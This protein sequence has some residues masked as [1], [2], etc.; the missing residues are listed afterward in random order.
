VTDKADNPPF[1]SL[2]RLPTCGYQ[3][4]WDGWGPGDNLG[5]LNRLTGP[6]VAA[7][8]GSVRTGMRIGLTLPMELPD[9]GFFGRKP[10]R[11][12]YVPM[13][14]TAWDDYVDGL[15]LQISSQ[16]D[17]LRHVGSA[18]GWYGGWRGDPAADPEPLGIHH[19]AERGIIGRGVLVDLAGWATSA[20][21]AGPD[22]YDPFAH[23]AFQPDDVRAALAAQG[24]AL[25]PG[26]ILC[27]RTGWAEKYLTLDAAQRGELA[28][29]MQGIGGFNSA[30]L[31][32]SEDMARFLW[33]SG[34]AAVAAD[35]PSV[36][37][38][39]VDPAVGALHGRLIGPLGMA[40]GELF[41]FAALA[42]ACA[43]EKRYEFLFTAVPL[44][45]AG[46][47]GSP[48]NAVAIL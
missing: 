1:D 14:D 45:V 21:G 37:S 39:P 5:T 28:G 8:A 4:S 3:H 29:G 43:R 19:W 20:R 15:Y 9:P 12:H 24:A 40:I 32:G 30:G 17:G 31:T 48:A 7:A 23:V 22:G 42:Q 10:F 44:N 33:D 46:A 35:N 16:W 26:D 47:V 6:V 2:P 13:G 11:H 36:E 41:S 18:D 34:V 27:V 38:V 25:R